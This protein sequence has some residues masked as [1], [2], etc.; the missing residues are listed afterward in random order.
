MSRVRILSVEVIASKFHSINSAMIGGNIDDS[1]VG[2][3]R[4]ITSRL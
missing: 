1:V 2:Q 4:S 3:I